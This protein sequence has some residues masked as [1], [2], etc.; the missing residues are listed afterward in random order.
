[1]A[2]NE[3]IETTEKTTAVAPRVQ[4]ALALPMEDL[5]A[6]SGAGLEEVGADDIAVPYL[7]ILQKQSKLM[8]RPGFTGKPGQFVHTITTE[9][10]DGE[11]GVDVIPC[12]FRRFWREITP[13]PKNPKFIAEHPANWSRAKGASFDGPL[14]RHICHDGTHANQIMRFYC[15]LVSPVETPQPVCLTFK[16]SQI[17]AAKAWNSMLSVMTMDIPTDQGVRKVQAPTFV[18]LWNL[19]TR[20]FENEDG[21][22]YGYEIVSAGKLDPIGIE[23]EAQL[24]MQARDFH[25]MVASGSVVETGDE[26]V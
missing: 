26:D 15:L 23:S 8:D 9:L 14:R 19:T 2:K 18:S 20:R 24:Y 25:A 10:Y 13:D 7:S 1:M 5:L 11:K 6:D 22:W 3:Q 17:K 16:G 4:S 21:S 12:H